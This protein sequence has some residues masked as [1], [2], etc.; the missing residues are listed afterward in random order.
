MGPEK[1]RNV[2]VNDDVPYN[3]IGSVNGKAYIVGELMQLED[4]YYI[5]SRS[6]RYIMQV[7]DIIIGKITHRTVDCYKVELGQGIVGFLPVLNFPNATKRNKPELNPD[8]FVMCRIVKLNDYPLLICEEGMGK[9]DGYVIELD[10]YTARKLLTSDILKKIGEKY[11]YKIGIGLNGR[12]WIY[13]EDV[14]I[15]KNVFEQI[16]LE[17]KYNVEDKKIKAS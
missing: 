12:I 1:I 15:V 13:N 5:N 14:E 3:T 17:T 4:M 6:L 2:F 7:D 8:E 9:I 10:C 16:C 11:H